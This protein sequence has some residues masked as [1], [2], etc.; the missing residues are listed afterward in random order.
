MTARAHSLFLAGRSLQPPS[1]D[2]TTHFS[3]APTGQGAWLWRTFAPYGQLRAQGLA[4]TRKQ[5]AAL[6][7]RDILLA[8]CEIAGAEVSQVSAKAA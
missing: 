3:I 8:R 4:P 7:I 2:E 6:V 5:A 1:R